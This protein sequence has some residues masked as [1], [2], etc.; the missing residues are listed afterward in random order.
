M[1]MLPFEVVKV[2][3]SRRRIGLGVDTGVESREKG[4][5]ADGKAAPY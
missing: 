2:G 5:R 1:L 4:I 3:K